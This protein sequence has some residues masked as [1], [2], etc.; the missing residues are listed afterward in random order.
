MWYMAQLSS[1]V[2]ITASLENAIEEI[3]AKFKTDPSEAQKRML[4]STYD[5]E[6]V[7]NDEAVQN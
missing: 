4:A 7:A 2:L 6:K 1:K 5:L 3:M